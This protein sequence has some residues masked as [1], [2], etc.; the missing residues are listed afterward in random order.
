MNEIFL[1][2][3]IQVISL[4][5]IFAFTACLTAALLLFAG[6]SSDGSEYQQKTYTAEEGVQSLQIDVQDRIVKIEIT[7]GEQ[8]SVDYFESE[9]ESYQISAEG[10]TLSIASRSNKEWSDFIG[11]KAPAEQRT[12]TVRL[13]E[14]KLASLQISATNEDIQLPALT[15]DKA[16]VYINGGSVSFDTLE[17]GESL[18]METKNGSV[19]GT[20]AG[21]YDDFAISTTIKK[22]DNNLP[23]QKEGGEKTLNVTVN[24]GDIDIHFTK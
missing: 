13:P 23:E 19:T 1:L 15:L 16:S 4:K 9:K 22:G 3:R 8:M 17:I 21:G 2:E 7:D 20:V 6:C 14:N 24:N 18:T 12:L 10:G 5:K 11:G